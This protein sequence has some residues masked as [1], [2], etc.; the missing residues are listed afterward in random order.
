VLGPFGFL[1][2]HPYW[3]LGPAAVVFVV[4]GTIQQRIARERL[5]NVVTK[6]PIIDWE[7]AKTKAQMD[8]LLAS[9]GPAG[10]RAAKWTLVWDFAFLAAYGLMLSLLCSVGARNFRASGSSAAA[11][12]WGWGA[13]VVLAAPVL[14]SVENVLLWRMLRPFEG[15]GLPRLMVRVSKAKWAIGLAGAVLLA[16][17]ALL[18]DLAGCRFGCP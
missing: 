3:W 5:R 1:T 8:R 6:N 18:F 10:R 16:F 12:V 13:W 2:D 7:M 11:T 4:T 14:D 15:D 17:P 9:W